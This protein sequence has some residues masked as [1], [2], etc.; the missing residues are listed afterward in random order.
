MAGKNVLFNIQ[1][2]INFDLFFLDDVHGREAEVDE[3]EQ[4]VD[5]LHR[6]QAPHGWRVVGAEKI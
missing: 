5:D 3:V 4:G 1:L 6:T 2:I